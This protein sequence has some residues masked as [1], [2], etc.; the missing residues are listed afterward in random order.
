MRRNQPTSL[1]AGLI[2]CSLSGVTSAEPLIISNPHLHITWQDN[3]LHMRRSPADTPF[4]VHDIRVQDGGA[5]ATVQKLAHPNWGQGQAILL[6]SSTGDRLQVSLFAELPFAVWQRTLRNDGD[7][8]RI[9]KKQD[10]LAGKVDLQIP[11][12]ELKTISTAGLLD[13]ADRPGSYAFMAVGDPASYRGIVCGW[14]THERG[15]GVVLADGEQE[16]ANLKAHIDYGDLRIESQQQVKTEKLLVGCFD[17]IRNGLEQ[18]GEAIATER[19]IQLPAQPSVYCTWYHGGASDES[20]L[21]RNTDFVRDHLASYR[22]QVMQID[23]GWQAGQSKNGPEKDFSTIRAGGPYA[24]GMKQTADYISS[25]GLAPGIWFM[26]FAGTWNDPYWADKQDLFYQEGSSPYNYI[27]ETNGGTRPDFPAGQAPFVTRWGG[28]C[29]DM[30]NPKTQEYL[31]S[32]VERIAHQWGYKYFKMD[33]LWTGTGTR[34]QYVNSSYQDDDLGLTTRFNPLITP[35]EAYAKGLDLVRDAAGRD[36][37]LLGCCAPQNMRSLGPAFGRVDAMRVGPDNGARPSGLVRGPLFST[38]V[39]FLNKRVWFNDPDPAYVRP[40]F[41]KQMAQTSVSWTALTGSLHSSSYSYSELPPERLEI[42]K[43]SLP[44]H[45]LKTVRPIDYLENDPA[46]VWQLIDDRD[47]IRKDVIGLFNWDVTHSASIEYPLHRVDLPRA[48]QDANQSADQYVGFDFWANRF[49]PPF[50]NTIAAD[51]PPGGCAILSVRPTRQHPQVVSTSRHLTQGVVDLSDERWEQAE[52]TLSGRSQLVGDD[53]YEIRVVVPTGKESWRLMEVQ[54]KEGPH[55]ANVSFVQTGPTIRIKIASNSDCEVAWSARFEPAEISAQTPSAIS[56][57][58]ATIDLDQVN[59]KWNPSE[60]YGY[61]VQRDGSDM[62]ELSDITFRDTTVQWGK[63][64]RYTVQARGWT[65]AWSETA[66][67]SVTMPNQPPIPTTP[68]LPQIFCSDL[69][70]KKSSSGWGSIG[71]DQSCMARPLTV[72]GKVYEKGMGVHA[73]STLVYRIPKGAN[74]FVASVGLDDEKSTDPRSSVVFKVVGDVLEM[75]EPPIVLARS[76]VLRNGGR[77]LWHFNVALDDR[78]RELH[79]VVE[80]G[81]DGIAAD[82]AD[83][84]N[85]GFVHGD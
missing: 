3:A 4:L 76:P 43:R 20:K 68:P 7:L 30:T 35:I 38:R 21:A 23:D 61:R 5:A 22:L 12:S 48:D 66:E 13:L 37:F 47:P 58:S 51:L 74:H 71:V 15:S 85:A 26:P 31:K 60:A 11:P 72:E 10:M 56:E 62:A 33:G 8:Q 24:S 45:S 16:T 17:D 55:N 1:L 2:L 53:D 79:L 75:G 69:N 18:Y 65:D 57:L 50:S 70:P 32:I 19:K 44:S 14:L 34:L 39:F 36:V 77:R 63:A 6:E 84:L 80:D 28:T 49:L 9:V 81:G 27:S 54:L 25:Q 42:L 41:P 64:Y 83:W 67:V 73:T 78:L 52:T 82:H 40:S 46:Q 59:L 29:L